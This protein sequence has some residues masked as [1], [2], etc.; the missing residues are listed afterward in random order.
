[1]TV[2]LLPGHGSDYRIFKDLELGPEYP[3]IPVHYA[4]PAKGI[5][6][7]EYARE[8]IPQIDTGKPFAL[9]G[10]S[11]GGL[12]SVE[13][14]TMI[15][16]EA[17]III[18]SARKRD[19]LPFF[20]RFLK[21]FPLHRPVPAGWLKVGS[22]IVQPLYE[23]DRK[24]NKET[25]V[26]MLHDRDKHF[27]KR[28]ITMIAHWDPDSSGTVVHIH[29]TKD[30]TIPY[31]RVNPDYTIEGGSHMMTLTR[32]PEISLLIRKILQGE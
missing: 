4:V 26:A 32:A 21:A 18:S 20:Y 12:L 19:E 6:M 7:R 13:L 22:Y 24:K 5:S 25:F 17:V 28:G 3:L 11:M 14:S 10:V 2:Y 29:G 31:R 9:V 16:P 15:H 8:L 1:M 30:H 27:L 23:P